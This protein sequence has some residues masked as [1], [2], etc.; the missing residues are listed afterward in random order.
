[1]ERTSVETALFISPSPGPEAGEKFTWKKNTLTVSFDKPLEPGRTYVISVGASAR[2]QRKNAMAASYTWAFSTGDSIDTGSIAGRLYGTDKPA[3][4][5][6]WAYRLDT[7]SPEDPFSAPG[8]YITQTND[9]GAF[10]LSYLGT[11]AYRVF[12]IID[13]NRDF[14]YASTSDMIAFPPGDVRAESAADAEPLPFLPV[15]YDTTAPLLYGIEAVDRNNLRALFN[16]QVS[17][18]TLLPENFRIVNLETGNAIDSAVTAVY[19]TGGQGAAVMMYTEKL[20]PGRK[21]Q[22]EI[23]KLAD[24]MGNQLQDYADSSTVFTASSLPDTALFMLESVTP[25]DSAADVPAFTP[26]V[27]KFNSPV[28]QNLLEKHITLVDSLDNRVPSS[29]HAENP[30]EFRIVPAETLLS[31]MQY[32]IKIEADSIRNMSGNILTILGGGSVFT[33]R[34][35]RRTGDLSG[36][37]AIGGSAADYPVVV[38]I[39]PAGAS[40]GDETGLELPGAGRFGFSGLAPGSYRLFAFVDKNRDG[41]WF[42]G[43]IRPFEPAEPFAFYEG[44]I[45]IRAGIENRLARPLKIIVH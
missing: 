25:A 24:M 12:L 21:Y 36:T 6:V 41:A 8:D 37:I 9:E 20:I 3:G 16:E 2:D 44:E 35:R 14:L 4:A 39:S 11:G 34:N 28:R 43:R 19:R 27:L 22:L 45:A 42:P 15:K 32:H 31:M 1:M 5:L 23:L 40:A 10:V 13:E 33:V 7:G 18:G 17:S 38:K 29:L 30:V 26:V